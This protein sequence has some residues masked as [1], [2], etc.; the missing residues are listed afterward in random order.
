MAVFY[1]VTVPQLRLLIDKHTEDLKNIALI[2]NEELR[3]QR[4]NELLRVM[5]H[6]SDVKSWNWV[7]VCHWLW[8][9]ACANTTVDVF[10]ENKIDGSLLLTIDVDDLMELGVKSR[11]E[12]K[13]VLANRDRLLNS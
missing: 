7:K 1:G 4:V 10:R 13:R 9:V 5:F 12:A 11:L 2:V 8:S 6:G 3:I